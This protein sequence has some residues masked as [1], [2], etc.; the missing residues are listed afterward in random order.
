MEFASEE[1]S[2][3][4]AGEGGKRKK[5]R[6]KKKKIKAE[7]DKEGEATPASG[8]SRLKRHREPQGTEEPTTGTADMFGESDEEPEKP[9]GDMVAEENGEDA[10]RPSKRRNVDLFGDSDDE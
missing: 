1:E 9:A 8:R 2:K 10:H 5:M 3:P 6:M 7:G 4:E